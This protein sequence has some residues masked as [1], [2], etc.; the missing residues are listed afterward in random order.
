M[1]LSFSTK[2]K[3]MNLISARPQ[4]D[5]F[6]IANAMLIAPGDPARSILY[7]RLSRRGRGQM[8]PVVISSIDEKAL[9]LFR[10]WISGM[11]TEQKFIRDWTMEDLLPLLEN[12][13]S[14]RSFESGQAA[15]KQVGC[16]QCHKFAGEGGSVGPE[17][18]GAGSRLS[19]HD[20]AE[21]IVLPSKVIAEGYAATE[22][23]TKSGEIVS[24]RIVREDDQTVVVL[25]QTA[26]AD[27][28][29][30]SKNDIR[31]R[32]LSKVSNMSA[33]ILNTLQTNQILDLLAY[34]VSD[35]N[36]NH[37]SFLAEAPELNRSKQR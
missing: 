26:I 28:T 23:E 14:G 35:G 1:T 12:T 15:F 11:N 6:G 32:Q 17:L 30:L 9:V 22:I 16:G 4:H 25:P 37:V 27:T 7:Q 2:R 24:G 10:D 3:D 19:R 33:G 34:L 21:S 8:P 18:T 5:T 29:T 31:R 13:K 36:S 20:L